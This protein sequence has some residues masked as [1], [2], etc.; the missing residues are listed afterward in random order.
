MAAMSSDHDDAPSDP[1][2]AAPAGTTR[3]IADTSVSS[4]ANGVYSA[5][6]HPGWWITA[7]PNGGY[8]AAVVLRAIIAEVADTTRRPRT[9]TVHYLRPPTAGPV[10]VLVTVERSGRTVTNVSARLIQD[11]RVMALALAALAADRGAPVAFDETRGLPTSPDGSPLPLPEQILEREV[12]PDRD[13][14]M[15]RHYDMR[16]A[17]G[18]LPF[19][20]AG[21]PADPSAPRAVNG[22]WLRPA[23]QEPIDEVVLAAM[24]D[25]WLPP[26]FS[27]V[28]QPL[29]VPT[30]DLTV[31][32]RA[33]PADPLDFCFVE[34][35]SPLAADGYLV[36][37][38][39]IMDRHGRL[40]AESRQLAVTI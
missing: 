36:E 28:H 19:G 9:L 21:A 16:W 12:D 38:G 20:L 32:F 22:G 3:F 8:V 37:H 29:A 30:I 15:R 25:A 10:Q 26:I 39:R 31:H 18:S 27:R 11:D 6:M 24:T 33:L 7:G 35:A 4:V 2:S 17:L 23:E 14:P 1:A 40:L 13:V 34:F 5:Q